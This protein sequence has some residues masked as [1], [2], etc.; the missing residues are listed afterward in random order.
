MTNKWLWK[1]CHS[2]L[3]L[4]FASILVRYRIQ[5][6]TLFICTDLKKLSNAISVV[7][8]L[9][10]FSILQYLN[11]EYEDYKNLVENQDSQRKGICFKRNCEAGIQGSILDSVSF[12]LVWRD[13]L[14]YQRKS[15]TWIFLALSWK[16]SDVSAIWPIETHR[17][18][19]SHSKRIF[20]WG[21]CTLSSQILYRLWQMLNLI[22]A[23]C[24]RQAILSVF[25]AFCTVLV[26][27]RVL[28]NTIE[29]HFV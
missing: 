23:V 25:V 11:S 18:L 26:T 17:L 2:F 12:G 13:Y 5:S 3:R 15:S 27:M 8:A 4:Y 24:H 16:K 19:E 29:V 10:I 28:Q 6:R 7:L 14:L 9:L 20:V 1:I 22:T 21:K